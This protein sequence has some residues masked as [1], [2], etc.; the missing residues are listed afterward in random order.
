[1]ED[2]K[3]QKAFNFRQFEEGVIDDIYYLQLLSQKGFYLKFQVALRKTWNNWRS[4][5][6]ILIKSSAFV[7]HIINVLYV[8]LL[9]ANVTSIIYSFS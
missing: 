1:M 5:A 8:L 7:K 9:D 3:Q 6:L 4:Q 2:K